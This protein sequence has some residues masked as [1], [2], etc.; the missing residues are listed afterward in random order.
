MTCNAMHGTASYTYPVTQQDEAFSERH[1]S[2]EGL[3]LNLAQ[4]VRLELDAVRAH[5]QQDGLDAQTTAGVIG[6]G[7]LWGVTA[8]GVVLDGESGSYLVPR[9]ASWAL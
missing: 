4:E 9:P 1:A 8:G 7:Q 6:H 3:V 2:V 5:A